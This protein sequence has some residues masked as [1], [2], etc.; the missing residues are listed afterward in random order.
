MTRPDFTRAEVLRGGSLVAAGG[1]LSTALA[2]VLTTILGIEL[3]DEGFGSYAFVIATAG[4]LA[5]VARLGLGPI[6]VRDI[7]RSVDGASAALGSRTPILTAISITASLGLAIGALTVSPIGRSLLDRAGDIQG[8]MV[9]ALAVLFASQALYMTN[10]ASLRGLHHLGSAAFFGLPVQRLVS[11]GLVI[12]VVYILGDDFT[13]R[14]AVWFVAAAAVTAVA[15]SGLALWRRIRSLPGTVQDRQGARRMARDGSPILLSN[16]LGIGATRLPVWVLAILGML[17]EAGVFALATA[18]VTMIR[19]GH[20]TLIGT[21]SPFVATS[22]HTGS[23]DDLQ[24]RV[25]VAAAGS[26]LSA[27]VASVAMVVAGTVVVPRLFPSGFSDAVAVAAILLVGT[28][29]TAYTGPCGLLLNVSGNE[30]WM[31]RAS[32]ISIAV[33][34]IAIFPAGSAWGAVGGAIVMAVTITIRAALQWRFAS[35][36][37]GIDTRADFGAL[38]HSFR[39]RRA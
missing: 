20:K 32:V 28:I 5:A 39:K 30:R 15:V 22:Y 26:T 2:A 6:V 31:A 36:Q 21:L 24:R 25:R 8:S 11:L 19:F 10:A 4:L 17:G 1:I 16:V 33:A 18:Y 12:W 3:G 7:A 9:A 38:W 29:A 23:R 13:P 34:A 35:A 27:L 37:T 14:L